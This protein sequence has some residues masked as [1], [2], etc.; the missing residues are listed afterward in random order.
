MACHG[1]S[2][3]ISE[4]LD[5]SK[6]RAKLTERH[7]N[8]LSLVEEHWMLTSRAMEP[9]EVAKAMAEELGEAIT[10]MYAGPGGSRQPV[11]G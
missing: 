11:R 2:N 7:S 8:M 9:A 4:Q 5:L 10:D 6:V 1:D 3:T